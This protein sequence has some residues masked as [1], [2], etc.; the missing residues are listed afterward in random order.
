MLNVNVLKF[1]PG[2]VVGE[3]VLSNTNVTFKTSI[4]CKIAGQF[5][6]LLVCGS[7][8][9]LVPW[10]QLSEGSNSQAFAPLQMGQL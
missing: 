10:Q 2:M 7:L 6:A 9:F 5:L 4:W 1:A 3:P 8:V